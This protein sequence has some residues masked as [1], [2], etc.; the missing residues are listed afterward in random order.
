LGCPPL[1]PGRPCP[2]RGEWCSLV[3]PA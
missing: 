2:R 1:R 3:M